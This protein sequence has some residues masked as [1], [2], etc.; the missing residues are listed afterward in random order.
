MEFTETD[1]NNFTTNATTLQVTVKVILE[2]IGESE[3][4]ETFA[5]L[6]ISERE[7][8]G[9]SREELAEKIGSSAQLLSNWEDGSTLPPREMVIKMGN[10]LDLDDLELNY[11]LELAGYPLLSELE[12]IPLPVIDLRPSRPTTKLSDVYGNYLLGNISGDFQS[13][14]ALIEDTIE[15]LGDKVNALE[16]SLGLISGNVSELRTNLDVDILAKV[17]KNIGPFKDDVEEIKE[18]V[19]RLEEAQKQLSGYDEFVRENVDFLRNAVQVGGSLELMNDRIDTF[20]KRI[21]KVES[22]INISRDR[23]VTIVA[24]IVAVLSGCFAFGSLA[25]AIIQAFFI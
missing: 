10:V 13:T 12:R 24:I 19:P 9:I 23:V 14:S 6:L 17:E 15:V 4:S 18:L 1:Y 7:S 20:E 3:M 2:F 8:K 5:N 16:N 25:V 21:D 11:L 22:Q